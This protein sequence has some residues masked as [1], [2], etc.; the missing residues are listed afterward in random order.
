MSTIVRQWPLADSHRMRLRERAARPQ[1]EAPL[2]LQFGV[3]TI[4]RPRAC[5]A[6][7]LPAQVTLSLNE[8]IEPDP[9][10]GVEPITGGCSPPIPSPMRRRSGASAMPSAAR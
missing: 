2:E 7:E 5:G 8:L 6:P 9:P 3:V 4:A 1:R 10:Q